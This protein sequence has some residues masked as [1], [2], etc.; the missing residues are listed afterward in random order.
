MSI[1]LPQESCRR[2]SANSKNSSTQEVPD[3]RFRELLQVHPAEEKPRE[4]NF[5]SLIEEEEKEEMIDGP[6]SIQ[7][8][9]LALPALPE[10][11]KEKCE[12]V[13]AGFTSTPAFSINLS[14][15]GASFAAVQ[16][17]RLEEFKELFEAMA[18]RMIVMH[19][20]GE[21]KTTLFLDNPS[22]RFFGTT[23]TIR[24]FST[25]PK[26]FNVEIASSTQ[27]ICAIEASKNDLLSAF[28]HGNFNFSIHRLD[29]LLQNEEHP[30]MHR[31]ENQ[32]GDHK[33]QNGGRES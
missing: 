26:V 15:L 2:T 4:K 9:P 22:S 33:D 18:S 25:A 8:L 16:N 31:D 20:S 6:I 17:T 32:D 21:V 14:G 13:E 30:V 28:Q 10:K 3:G 27:M 23:I 19:S 12:M 1:Y 11:N 7:I 5:F 29:T 24:E